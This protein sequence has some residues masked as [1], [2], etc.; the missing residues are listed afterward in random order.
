MNQFA[1]KTYCINL[2]RRPDR[3]QLAKAEFDKHG[4]AVE[5]FYAIDGNDF[6]HKYGCDQ[7]NNGCT[8]SHYQIIQRAMFLGLD[9]VM[10]FEDDVVLHDDFTTI[11][12]TAMQELPVGWDML[13]FG[14]SHREPPRDY[15][16]YLL[17]VRRTLTTHGYILHRPA[18]V[19]M[20][21]LLSKLNEPVD[22]LFTKLQTIG[23]YFVTN[24]PIAWQRKGFSDIVGREMHYPWLQT[25]QQ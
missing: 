6:K 18:F 17:R 1:D 19:L 3:W 20:L 4:L 24:P 21:R 7:A 14:G 12:S 15:S 25:N 5:R 8:L 13:Y 11:L 10:V 9:S 2:D 16:E 22:C 23:G